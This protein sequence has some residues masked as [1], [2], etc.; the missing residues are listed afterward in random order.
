MGECP[1]GKIITDSGRNEEQSIMNDH[2]CP[3]IEV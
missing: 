3:V 2:C 1:G